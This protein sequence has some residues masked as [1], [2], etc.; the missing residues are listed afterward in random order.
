MK[1]RHI[2]LN[3]RRREE[4]AK[5]DTGVSPERA[6]EF[7][8]AVCAAADQVLSTYVTNENLVDYDALEASPAYSKW[9]AIACELPRLDLSQLTHDEALALFINTYNLATVQ[10]IV[11]HG[12]SRF[13]GVLTV[14]RF[15]EN[16]GYTIGGHFFS[17]DDMEHGILRCTCARACV[18]V[19]ACV[20]LCLCAGGG[21]NGAC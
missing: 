7:V 2:S 8:Q 9:L 3:T 13:A 16:Y 14:P 10:A 12:G 1:S 18:C 15:W 6:S 17:L 21:D 4:P 5:Q 19:C 20:P 11:E